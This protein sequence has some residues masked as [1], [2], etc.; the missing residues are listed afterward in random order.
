MANIVPFGEWMPDL[1]AIQNPGAL[2]VTN[3]YPKQNSYGPFGTLAPYSSALAARCQG[4]LAGRADDGATSVFAGDATKLYLMDATATFNDVSRTVGYTTSAEESWRFCQY[5]NRVITT[6]WTDA[7]QTW[8]LGGDTKFSDLSSGAPKARHVAVLDP[9]F[10]MAGNTFDGVDGAVVNRVWWSEFGVPTSWP[11]IGTAAAEAAQ[12]DFND[13][14]TGGSVQAVLGAVG[15][16]AGLVVCETALYRVDYEG[17]PTVF[18]FT[19]IERLRGTPAPNSVVN[20]GPFA[21]YLGDDDF[22]ICDG[23][24]SKPIGAGKIAKTFFSELNQSYYDRIS[25]AVDPINKLI[26]WT[27]PSIASQN[28]TPDSCIMVNWETWRWSKAVFNSE[29]IF[30]A[31]T[32]GYTLDS[33]DGLGYTLD[34]LQFSLDSRVWSGGRLILA[35]FDASHKLSFFTGANLEATIDT[36]EFENQGLITYCDGARIIV[37]AGIPTLSI[38]HRNTPQGS[39]SFTPETTAGDDGVARQRVSA[40]YMR[41]RVKIPAGT[42][43]NHAQG[44]QPELLAEGQR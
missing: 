31:V 38:G 27:Y 42:D 39:V 30:R 8:V 6:N 10:V 40:R 41:A 29:F 28:G 1:P 33:L 21:A 25:A 44:V 36:G 11:A 32:A 2:T 37:D 7:I 19:N 34:S 43:W 26:L 9:G 18:R 15:G 14:P 12:S 22:Y 3:A 20:I 24:Q 4:A 23:A 5:A 17:P 35:A 16:A 13:L